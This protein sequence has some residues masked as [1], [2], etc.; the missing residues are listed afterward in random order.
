M[1][2]NK[3]NFE[4]TLSELEKIIYKLESGECTLEES[5]AL[6]EQGI[7]YTN[8]CRKALEKAQKKI[9]LLTEAEQEAESID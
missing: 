6:F 4:K 8:E 3:I 2:E 1:A 9:V 7:K 5:I